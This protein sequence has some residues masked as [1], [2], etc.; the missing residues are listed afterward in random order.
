MDLNWNRIGA[1]IIL[2]ILST[3][4][5]CVKAD[6]A[7]AT[8]IGGGAYGIFTNQSDISL[9]KFFVNVT[10]D[11][12][13]VYEEYTY[14]LKNNQNETI[15]QTVIIPVIFEYDKYQFYDIENVYLTVNSK[16]V[17]Y[18]ESSNVVIQDQD[19]IID[20]DHYVGYTAN[21]TFLPLES[22]E[23]KLI[24][25]STHND[26]TESFQYFYSAKT[27][28]YWNGS[29]NYGY[30]KFDYQSEYETIEFD[31]PNGTLNKSEITSVM[32][33]WDGNSTYSVLVYTGI[34]YQP[35]RPYPEVDPLVIACCLIISIIVI[36]IIILKI[37]KKRE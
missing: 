23:V 19:L 22:T 26:Y 27:S 13:D 5:L 20:M 32:H 21:I 15:N 30:F 34:G 9:E 18:F 31:V 24:V 33:S 8:I 36:L 1:V 2:L 35:P 14:Y 6:I 29:I 4:A 17:E 16:E 7:P 12:P 3:S 28:R 37:L 11:L 25:F 10:V